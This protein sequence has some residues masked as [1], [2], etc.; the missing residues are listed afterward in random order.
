MLHTGA[1]TRK[2]APHP[3][4]RPS[5]GNVKRMDKALYEREL[6]LQQ[7]PVFE[8]MLVDDGIILIKYWFSVSDTQQQKRF[9][10]RLEDP[11]RR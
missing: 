4:S 3:V 1:P 8:R 7:A 11:M 5:V 9:T 10:S 6:F 2:P